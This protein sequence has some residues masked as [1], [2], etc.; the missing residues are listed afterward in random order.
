MFLCIGPTPAAQRVMIF[1]RLTLERVNR[2]VTTLDGAAGKS[3]NVAK[4]LREL[5]AEPIAAGFVGGHWGE[6]IVQHLK[7]R[8][9]ATDFV[10][11]AAPTRQCVTVIDE[12]TGSVT[13]L[14][15][16]SS[17]V[18]AANYEQLMTIARRQL[19]RCKAVVLSGTITPGGPAGFYG[20]CVQAARSAN[21]LSLVDASGPALMEALKFG[22]GVVKP[23]RNELAVSVGRPLEKEAEV[24]E[25]MRELRARG[26]ERVVT[27]AGTEA[28]LAFDGQTFWRIKAPVVKALN[29]IGSGDA[30]TAGLVWRLVLGDNLGEACRWAAAAGAANALS[31]MPGDLARKDI[32]RLLA[33][34]DIHCF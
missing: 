18:L 11:V 34:V 23:N 31:A 22:P 12:A 6:T 30:F 29:P 25:A 21:V 15:Q 10:Q 14:V 1:P 19:P 32:D 9:I 4:V 27:T 16:E 3:V 20:A 24:A 26:A 2:A 8:G 5:G 13:E 17:A 7:S 33:E 28:T